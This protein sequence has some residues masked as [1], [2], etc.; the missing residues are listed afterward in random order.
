MAGRLEPFRAIAIGQLARALEAQGRSVVHMEFGQPSTPA[1]A[2]ALAA[3]REGLD[4]DPPGSWESVPLRARIARHYRDAYRAE[5]APAQAVLTC[6][7]SPAPLLAMLSRF[8]AGDPTAFARPRHTAYRNPAIAARLQP[9]EIGC[10]P[11]SRYQLTAAAIAALDPAPA[12]VILAS[13]ANP[14]GTI[15]EPEE[16]RAIADVCRQRGI[17]LLSDE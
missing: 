2:A 8:Q 13:P 6:G 7:A 14:T 17:V 16:L 1:P 4:R 9:V 5:V 15:I 12:G 11:E 3:V 10:G